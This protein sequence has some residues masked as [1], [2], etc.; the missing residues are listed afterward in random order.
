[1]TTD[2]FELFTAVFMGPMTGCYVAT[3][4]AAS[5]GDLCFL[6]ADVGHGPCRGDCAA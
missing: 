1:M 4:A 3:A 2:L 5:A 6:A